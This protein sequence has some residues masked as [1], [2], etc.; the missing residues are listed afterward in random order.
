MWYKYWS[1]KTTR[2]EALLF[3]CQADK[4]TEADKLFEAETGIDPIKAPW[5]G[6]QPLKE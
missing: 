4:I 5:V 1:N 2:H 3:E 6:C